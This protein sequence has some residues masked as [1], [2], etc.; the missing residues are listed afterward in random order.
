MIFVVIWAISPIVLIPWLISLLV[1]KKRSSKE[2]EEIREQ[3][4]HANLENSHLQ[5]RIKNLKEFYA[6][7]TTNTD[8]AADSLTETMVNVSDA[9]DL[10]EISSVNDIVIT[11]GEK[12]NKAAETQ[13]ILAQQPVSH[14]EE[15]ISHTNPVSLEPVQEKSGRKT[16][17]PSGTVMFGIGILF[18]LVAGAIFATTTWQILSSFGKVLTLLGAVA[19]FF[20]SS[21]LAEKKFGLRETS[22]TF[23]L[24]G[25][26]FLS[27]VNLGIAYFRWFGDLY[28]FEGQQT[29][30]VWSVSLLILTVCLAIGYKLYS[31]NL[32]GVLSYLSFL[33]GSMLLVRFFVETNYILLLVAGIYIALSWVYVYYR[34]YSGYSVCFEKCVDKVSYI[35]LILTLISVVGDINF[36]LAILILALGLVISIEMSVLFFG[37]LKNIGVLEIYSAVFVAALSLKILEEYGFK[38]ANIALLLATMVYVFIFK[39]V[40]VNED[41]VLGNRM[42]DILSGVLLFIASAVAFIGIEFSIHSIPVAYILTV[43]IMWIVALAILMFFV[44]GLK[45]QNRTSARFMD[46]VNADI[47]IWAV[48]IICAAAYSYKEQIVWLLVAAIVSAISY[49][50]YE[51]QESNLA[52]FV[53]A[54]SMFAM[55]AQIVYLLD[56]DKEVAILLVNAIFFVIA[57]IAGRIRYKGVFTVDEKQ[58]L[59]DWPGLLSVIFVIAA[60]ATD[61]Y[62]IDFVIFIML[63]VYFANFYGRVPKFIQRFLLSISVLM[64]GFAFAKW[65]FFEIKSSFEAEWNI[66]IVMAVIILWGF[67]WRNIEDIYSKV[68]SVVVVLIYI[69]YLS[70][71]YSEMIYLST[72]KTL[73]IAVL[74]MLFYLM[75]AVIA[76]GFACWKNKKYYYIVSGIILAGSASLVSALV[77]EWII[78]IPVLFGIGYTAYIYINNMRNLMLFPIVQLYLL[79]IGFDVPVYFYLPIFVVS[80]V[81]GYMKYDMVVERHG[82]GIELDWFTITAI[83]PLVIVFAGNEDKWFFCTGMM[84]A[85]YILSFYKRVTMMEGVN[86]LILT[87]V[88]IVMG[89]TMIKIPFFEISDSWE[90]EWFLLFT[91]IAIIFNMAFVYKD[92]TDTVK[93]YILYFFA[94]ASIIWQASDAISSNNVRD[95][96]ILGVS[97]TVLLI[98]SFMK[99]KKMWFLL[100]AIT[101]I[102]QGI[103]TSRR[104]WLSIAW[105]VYL[106][107]VGVLFIGIAAVNEYRKRNEIED[108]LQMNLFSDWNKW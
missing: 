78:I 1:N 23:Y 105:W 98:F 95:A 18:V 31:V 53:P 58:K 12:D 14:Y 102:L 71:I 69:T 40:K 100:A 8:A 85:A 66:T 101:L 63:A 68:A 57:F 38:P 90:T 74:K 35:F 6:K 2:M 26:S 36:V 15:T 42:S 4:K 77:S 9:V 73:Y 87:L 88:S 97:M 76:F 96:L 16:G 65:P 27:V 30:L 21:L 50:C 22:I 45:E 47:C 91:W 33:L 48:S 19:V 61:R 3:L 41:R 80:I 56:N 10:N 11:T 39:F 81:Y 62:F 75:G 34:Q 104:F 59:M 94:I 86:R 17:L 49:V 103:Y 79:L 37:K 89:I 108:H 46:F 107:V 29:F 43:L 28:A 92:A 24:L 83:I 51:L 32:L 52:G 13:D 67:I 55:L 93:Y 64:T 84:M 7:G 25:S 82:F 99:K 54:I 70:D 5:Q 106:L 60:S 20:I 72:G 44:F